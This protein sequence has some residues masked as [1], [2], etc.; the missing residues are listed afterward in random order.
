MI[1]NTVL[2]LAMA[3][4]FASSLY[5]AHLIGRHPTVGGLGWVAIGA[6]LVQD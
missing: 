6:A 2:L 4:A 3:A 1:A 5:L